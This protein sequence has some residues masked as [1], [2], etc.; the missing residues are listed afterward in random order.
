MSIGNRKHDAIPG[1]DAEAAG[2][3]IRCTATDVRRALNAARE[4]LPGH[5]RH[6]HLPIS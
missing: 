4:P 5:T 6:K 3:L 2:I 1:Q